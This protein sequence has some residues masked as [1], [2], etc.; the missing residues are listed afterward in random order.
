MT[1]IPG[2]GGRGRLYLTLHCHQPSESAL[3]KMGQ[4]MGAAVMFINS[5]VQS[6][7]SVHKSQILLKE[8]KLSRSRIEPGP[9]CLQA[10][11]LGQTSLPLRHSTPTPI[12]FASALTPTRH[13]RKRFYVLFCFVSFCFFVS[14]F[15]LFYLSS[16]FSHVMY[17]TILDD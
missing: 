6:Q 15:V 8:N 13:F 12:L 10:L 17:F 5:A 1:E 11:L 9:L 2:G 4:P 7:D 14:F 3:V 16:R